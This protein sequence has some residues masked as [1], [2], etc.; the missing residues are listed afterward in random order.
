MIAV[1]REPPQ[2]ASIESRN[3]AVIE[4]IFFLMDFPHE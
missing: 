3:P 2:R 1:E 4:A